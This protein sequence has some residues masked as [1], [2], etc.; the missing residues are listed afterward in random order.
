VGWR[1][2]KGKGWSLI[3]MDKIFE[4]IHIMFSFQ[5]TLDVSNPKGIKE[6]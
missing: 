4:F 5:R 2:I 6:D 1:G 3:L